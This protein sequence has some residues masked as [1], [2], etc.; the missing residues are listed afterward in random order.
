MVYVALLRGI[1]VGGN[2]LI[3][4][5]R[6]K[7]IF[8]QLPVDSVQTYINSGN[9]VFRSRSS[10][11][12]GLTKKIEAAITNDTGR[13]VS[14]LLKNRGEMKALV[15][16]IPKSWV[17]DGDMKCDVMFLWA[18]VDRPSTVKRFPANSEIEDVKYVKGAVLWRVDREHQSKSRM[19][20]IVGTDLYKKITIRNPNTVRK[21]YELMA[22]A[23]SRA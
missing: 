15:A 3:P 4:M 12:S 16:A 17:N 14:V 11:S 19:T 2:S 20:K 10:D 23:D 21:L 18:D 22:K 13:P 9:V 1:N 5:S 8:E 6:L 7:A